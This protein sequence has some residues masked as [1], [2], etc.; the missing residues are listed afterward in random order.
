V[1]CEAKGAGDDIICA[2]IAAQI[3]AVF[4]LGTEQDIIIP[5]AAKIVGESRIL[6]VEF[7][8]VNRGETVDADSLAPIAYSLISV[9]PTVP[10]IE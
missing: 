10:G 9:I 2:Q 7:G 5:V 6:I 1:I 3:G 4:S 8:S